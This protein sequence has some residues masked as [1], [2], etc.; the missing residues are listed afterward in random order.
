MRYSIHPT[1]Q[2]GFSQAAERYQ[3]VRPNYPQEIIAWLQQQ[4]HLN[5]DSQ[6]VDLG[7]GTGKFIA[8][9]TQ[10]SPNIIAV[11]PVT[12]MLQQLKIRYPQV[13]TLQAS[14]H[15]IPLPSSSIDA[16]ICAQAFHW[17]ADLKSLQSIHQILKPHAALGLVWNQRDEQVDWVKALADFIAE[18]ETDTPRFHSGAWEKVFEQQSL[19]KPV[20]VHH[21]AH[22]QRGCVE[23]VVSKRLLS[24]SFIAAMPIAQQLELKAKFEK[25]VQDMTGKQPQDQIEFPY[26]THAY[27]YEKI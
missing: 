18:Y 6:I 25:I 13:Q 19:F 27:H 10:V 4:L 15:H 24:T 11:E 23:D 8:A 7:A 16:V 20:A 12:E 22:V 26:Q 2:D 9:L 21:F 3:H 1:A 17:F 14:S 5:G